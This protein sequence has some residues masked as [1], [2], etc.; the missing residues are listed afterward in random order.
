MKPQS[1]HTLESFDGTRLYYTVEGDGPM[2]YLLA[3]GI[4]CDGFIWR[5]L[6]PELLKRGRVVHLHMRGHGRSDP[7]ADPDAIETWHLAD[8]WRAVLDAVGAERAVVLGHSMGVQVSLELVR[9]DPA[10]MAGMVLV[11]GS[12]ENPVETFHDSSGA[13]KMLPFLQKGTQLGG[14]TLATIWKRLVSLPVAFHFARLTEIDPDLARRRDMERYLEHLS[15]M[16]PAIFF[17]MLGG[18]A[19]HSARDY[20]ADL[21]VPALVLA[22]SKDRFTPAR[23]SQEMAEGLPQGH[24]VIVEDGTHT[25]PI[26]QPTRVNIEVLRFLDEHFGQT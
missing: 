14:R 24:E 26:E 5:Y 3:D 7:P 13:G 15:N 17:H 20:L 22:G 16:D 8:D 23:L 10:R 18:A 21:D 25:A 11:C 12:F 4:G 19:R 2:H 1:E 9:R 6:E